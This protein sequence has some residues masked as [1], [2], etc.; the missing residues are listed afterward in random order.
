MLLL[1]LWLLVTLTFILMKA[2][3]GDPFTQE[4][5]LPP[6][7]VASLYQYYG[8]DQPIWKQYLDYLANLVRGDFGPSYKYIG[9]SVDQIIAEGFPLSALLGLEAFLF[10]TSLGLCLGVIAAA[11]QQRWEDYAVTLLTVIG[12]SVPSF[13][14]ATLLQYLF[15]VR[16]SWFP[17]GSWGS[18]SHTILPALSLALLPAAFIARMV[19][20]S[21]IET[22]QQDF[23]KTAHAKGLP[24]WRV[25]IVHGLK[26]SLMPVVPYFGT[27]LTNL[28][29]GS[30]VIEKIF[31]IP[32]LGQWYVSSILNRDYT[33]ILGLTLFYGFLLLT[34]MFVIDLVFGILDPRIRLKRAY[35]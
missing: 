7:I 14:L 8:L 10:A 20:N 4:Q 13:I 29:A 26:N 35:V 17:V 15:A 25:L 19:R 2:I 11:H 27:L 21:M 6:E 32:G 1:T 23:I 16:L 33:V 28:L 18:F 12:V 34:M 30:F 5:S 9:Q 22:L 3:P 24:P 31:G